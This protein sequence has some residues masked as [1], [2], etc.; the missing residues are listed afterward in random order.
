MHRIV[1]SVGADAFFY[2]VR[3]CLWITVHLANRADTA[4]KKVSGFEVFK[5][6]LEDQRTLPAGQATKDLLACINYI[7]RKFFKNLQQNPLLAIEAFWPKPR[8]HLRKLSSAD[9]D[10]DDSENDDPSIVKV[11]MCEPQPPCR[12]L[13]CDI[14]RHRKSRPTWN[15]SLTRNLPGVRS[16]GS[17]FA[18]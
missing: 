11:R 9:S 1:V 12:R 15:S 7:L 13:R 2:K 6:V 16:W 17:R 18:A 10:R 8:G 3:M 4:I 14:S 5:R